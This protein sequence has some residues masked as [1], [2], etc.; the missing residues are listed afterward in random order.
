MTNFEFLQNGQKV[1]SKLDGMILEV[2]I[3]RGD[4]YFA[5]KRDMWSINEFDPADWELTK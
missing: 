3:W 4:V 2:K 5:G 1:K